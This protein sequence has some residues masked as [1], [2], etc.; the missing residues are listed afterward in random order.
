MTARE[1]QR[2]WRLGIA[3]VCVVVLVVGLMQFVMAAVTHT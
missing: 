3:A 1:A 2:V